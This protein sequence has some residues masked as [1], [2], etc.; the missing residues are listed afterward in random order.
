MTLE[1]ALK[2]VNGYIDCITMST[3]MHERIINQEKC[4][5]YENYAIFRDEVY[6]KKEF[7][8]EGYYY[9]DL[10]DKNKDVNFKTI[11]RHNPDYIKYIKNAKEYTFK[12]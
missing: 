11:A 6:T 4:L 10:N 7:D 12:K 3:D 9:I 8:D 1:E 2:E 5:V